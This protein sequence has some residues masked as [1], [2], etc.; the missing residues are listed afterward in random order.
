MGINFQNVKFK[1]SKKASQDTLKDI[2]LTIEGKGE[3]I[4]ILGHTGSGKS[5]LVQLMNALL[6]PTEGVVT[7]YNQAITGNKKQKLKLKPVRAHVG[8][9]FQFPEYQLFEDTV[10]KDILF[11]PKNFGKAPE[12]AK[13]EALRIVKL[14]NIP[15]ELLERSPFSL[16]GGQMRKVAIAGI[17]ASNPDILI[18]DEPTVGLDPK[19]KVEL[20]ELLVKIQE[21]T[22]KTIVMISHDMNMVAKYAKRVLVM[23][24][25]NL[26][27]DGNKLD[28][29]SDFDRLTSYNLGLPECAKLAL[30]LKKKNLISF[31]TLP[32]TK[33]ELFGVMINSS[34]RG[35]HH[36]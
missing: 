17:L 16:S 12:E 26:V 6:L 9:V 1:Y 25:G 19:G 34:L 33:E 21:V 35:E 3:F 5:T 7:V 10:L 20:M 29:F 11:G 14:L 36:E 31:E 30:E 18:L 4:A 15:D 8:L 27:Y 2:S 32:L 24:D 28:L 13:E 23:Q 22:N